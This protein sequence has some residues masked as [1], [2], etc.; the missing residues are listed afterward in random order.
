MFVG[1]MFCIWVGY[2]LVTYSQVK[3]LVQ[4]AHEEHTC[5]YTSNGGWEY[6]TYKTECGKEF[7]DSTEDVVVQDWMSYCPYCGGKVR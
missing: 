6:S 7:Y 4:P 3:P 2:K 1:L 5:R